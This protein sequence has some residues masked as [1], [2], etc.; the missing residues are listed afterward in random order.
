[1][2]NGAKE[3]GGALVFVRVVAGSNLQD[4]L[5]LL[6]FYSKW[7]SG[8]GRIWLLFFCV[9]SY[10][11]PLS[12]YLEIWSSVGRGESGSEAGWLGW[13]NCLVLLHTST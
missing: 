13:D 7:M 5:L 11:L 12:S 9:V 3:N 6:R 4:R 2:A 10:V 1:M 8:E